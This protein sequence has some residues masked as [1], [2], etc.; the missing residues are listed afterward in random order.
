MLCLFAPIS[1][2]RLFLGDLRAISEK[3]K[4]TGVVVPFCCLKRGLMGFVYNDYLFYVFFWST[5]EKKT[6]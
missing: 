6:L 1:K 2:K 3:T 4:R 5:N